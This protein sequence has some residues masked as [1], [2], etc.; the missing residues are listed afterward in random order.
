M[1]Q[2]TFKAVAA[3]RAVRFST[4][5]L[6][7]GV[8]LSGPAVGQ[9]WNVDADGDYETA[10][11]WTGGAPGANADL[12]FGDIITANRTVTLNANATVNSMVFS[13]VPDGGTARDYFL[14]ANSGEVLTMTGSSIDVIGR[15]WLNLEVAGT[16]GLNLT[17]TGELILDA[18]NTFTGG[19]NVDNVNLGILNTGSIASG[20]DITLT[21]GG[22]MRMWGADNGFFSD[23]GATGYGTGT[24]DGNI[25]IGDGSEVQVNDGANVTFTGVLS[26]LGNLSNAF[27]NGQMTIS[28]ANTYTGNTFV[29]GGGGLTMTNTAE[30]LFDIENI[31]A[32]NGIVGTGTADLDGTF[33]IDNAT[34]TDTAG[35]WSLVDSGLTETYGT[36]FGLQFVGGA[37]FVESTAGVWTSG[38]YTFRE[39]TGNLELGSIIQWAVDAAGSYGTGS[40]WNIGTAPANGSDILFGNIITANRDVTL[41]QNVSLNRISFN[42]TGDGDY[43]IVPAGSQTVTLTGD[44]EVNTTGRHWMRAEL[45]GTAGLNVAGEGE[46]V[47]DAANSFTGG[48]NVDNANLAILHADAI[49]LGNN[50]TVVNDAEM[51]FWGTDN[52]F[53]GTN[54]ATGYTTGTV[55]GTIDIDATSEVQVNDGATV[56]F[57]GVISGAGQLNN[58]AG[59]GSMILNAAN[60]YSGSTQITSG[61][62]TL[63]NNA[64]LGAGGGVSG[65]GTTLAGNANTGQIVLPGG[66]NIAGEVLTFGAREGAAVDTIGLASTGNNTWGDNI[67]GAAGGTNYNISSNGG[68]LTLNGILSAPDTGVR[69]YTFNGDGNFVVNQITDALVDP[70]GDF[71]GASVNNNVGIIKR[72][73][74]T[75]TITTASD[76]NDEFHAGPTLIQ[77]GTVV[78][79]SDG[80]NNGELRSTV[81]V[82]AGA[83]FDVTDFG[84]YNL[85]PIAPFNTGIGGG[86]TVLANTLGIFESNTVTP[87]DSVGTLDVTGNVLLRYFDTGAAT[88]P[89]TGSFNFELGNSGTVVGGAENDLID[90]TGTLTTTIEA[91]ATGS[92]FVFNITPAEGSLDTANNY[93]LIR[94]GSRTGNA[95]AANF[96]ANIVD[97]QGNPLVSRQT[98]SVVLVGNTVQLDVNGNPLNLTWTGSANDNWDVNTTANFTG[99]DTEFFQGDNVFF[100]ATGG[101]GDVNVAENV[102]PGAMT[103]AAAS[104][105]FSGSDINAGSVTVSNNAVASFSNTVGGNVTVNNTATL[106]GTGTFNN[107][108]TVQGG[109]T[110]RIGGDGLIANN[111]VLL[112]DFNSYGTGDTSTATGGVWQGEAVG[113]PNSNIVTTTKGNSLESFGGGPGW[114]GAERDLTGSGGEVAVGETKTYFWQVLAE[115]ASGTNTGANQLGFFDVMQ[116]LTPDVSNIDTTNAWQDFQVMPFINNAATTPFMNNNNG[117]FAA[118]TPGQWYDVWV[119]INNDATTPSYDLYMAEEGENPVLIGTSPFVNDGTTGG[120]NQ[121]LNAI[122]FMATANA[123]ARVL[124]DNIYYSIGET[125]SNPLA[126]SGAFQGETMVVM[127]DVFLAANATVSFDIAGTGVGDMLDIEGNLGVAD[128]FILEVLLDSAINSLSLEAGN[129]WDLFDFDTSSGTFDEGD[130]VL[131]TL[132]AGLSWDTSSLLVDGVLSILGPAGIEGDYNNGGQVEQTDLDFVLANWGDTDISD[133]TGWVNFPG[134]GAFDGLVDQNELDG[135]LLNWGS[136]SAPDFAGSAVPEPAGLVMFGLGGLTLLGNRRRRAS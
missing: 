108:V 54:G 9:T 47:L 90:I 3:R 63:N 132:A 71:A 92:Q 7:A 17:N 78:V 127:S 77:G 18:T 116:G 35:S 39:S 1:F 81:T 120:F 65:S 134:G 42:N 22:F 49:P 115:D 101:G 14:V 85:I 119:V 136:T 44:A 133:V 53:F 19:I 104:Y 30:L 123:D 12:T 121:D 52:V 31:N 135:V 114:Q 59:N 38:D 99:A 124:H 56:T 68:T 107:N 96:S 89:D 61:T 50:I 83:T 110:L 126:G 23:N 122:G 128:G 97:A 55:T 57:D 125:T 69:T 2:P 20:N 5:S 111:F 40:N 118:M 109:G 102:A 34:L 24:I 11:N 37:A 15:H 84:T 70:N 106:A 6:L 105:N 94:A 100:N 4:A 45:A 80:A 93:T 74:G 117:N 13:Q 25:A 58:F 46:F 103:V 72:G 66:R 86:G 98:A 8:G 43:F 26:G 16:S 60:T 27:G 87:G 79:E 41:D 29:V 10:G 75:L 129:S 131:P 51:R 28:A 32:S 64:S 21:N 82:N 112:D 33:M 91:A 36:N 88:V 113:N 95:T 62:V 76:L 67:V 48:L 73:A 130:F